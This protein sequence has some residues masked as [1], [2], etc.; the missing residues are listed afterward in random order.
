[1]KA[2]L[3]YPE[4]IIDIHSH[5][6]NLKYLPIAG[7]IVRYSHGWVPRIIARGFEWLLIH[8]TGESFNGAEE[9]FIIK[10]VYTKEKYNQKL[11]DYMGEDN[12]S[13]KIKEIFTFGNSEA[14]R[15]IEGMVL[16]GD[17]MESKLSEALV[18]F[19][20]LE[21]DEEPNSGENF[22]FESLT[23]DEQIKHRAGLLQ[24]MLN[25]IIDVMEQGV[26][27]IRWFIFMTNSEEDIYKHITKKDENGA[28]KYLHMM[29]DVDHFFNKN[30][31]NLKYES[32]FD[33]EKQLEN[34]QKLN[35]KHDN[36]IGFVAFNPA[37]PDSLELVK[38]AISEKGFKGV[39]FYPPLGYK[40]FGD[41]NYTNEIN[42]LM[43]YCSDNKIPLFTHCNN[44]GFE[45][46][47]G[48]KHS[49]YCS[50][51][52]YWE[53][54]LEQY[55]ELILCLGHAG[56]CEGWFSDNKEIDHTN[57]NDIVAVDIIDSSEVQEE[58]W[59]NSYA[60]MVYK[61]CVTKPNVYCD[62]SYLDEMINANDTFNTEAH[63]NFKKRL[64]NLFGTNTPYNFSKKIM[65]GS[66]WHMLF[67]EAKNG[68]YLNK[69]I[70]FFSDDEFDS[71][72]NDFFYKNAQTL[73]SIK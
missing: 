7:I 66:D 71:Y 26:N 21:L 14:V 62:A 13:Y 51:P 18:E 1:M 49:G 5:M 41:E 37:R 15:V 33:Y 64:L 60:A 34:M 61:L 36:L 56:G 39:K 68:I 3:K 42:A 47:P 35:A 32:Y 27:Y 43:Q 2:V 50:H 48:K 10:P 57:P 19:E 63:D 72:R 30:K 24:R 4:K 55:P 11:T 29:M 44:Q 59:N 28:E 52:K 9:N 73:L 23:E 16:V 65:Y 67:Q 53:M 20:K 31:K 40:P 17:V 69:Y 70:E 58:N 8:N 54:L 22:L 6:F 45:A 12:F 25:K 46:W 38:K